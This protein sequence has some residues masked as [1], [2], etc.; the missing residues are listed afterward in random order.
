MLNH[1]GEVPRRPVIL[2]LLNK[3][4]TV[5]L[6]ISGA[7]EGLTRNKVISLAESLVLMKFQMQRYLTLL[8]KFLTGTAAEILL[9]LIK[10]L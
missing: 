3:D 8:M 5:I 6:F 2:F 7:L 1:K 9:K 10:G 4:I